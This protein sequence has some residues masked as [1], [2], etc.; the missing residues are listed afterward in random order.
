M[1]DEEAEQQRLAD[2]ETEKQRLAAEEVEHQRLA[3]EETKQNKCIRI[4]S[5]SKQG[6]RRAGIQFTNDFQDIDLDELS[7]DQQSILSQELLRK[8]HSNL[9]VEKSE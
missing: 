7:D 9:I 3:D 2:E 4:R 1:A 5:R 6:F 8:E